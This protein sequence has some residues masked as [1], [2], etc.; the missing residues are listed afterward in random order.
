MKPT[1]STMNKGVFKILFGDYAQFLSEIELKAT[2]KRQELQEKLDVYRKSNME[3]DH[4][5]E[6]IDL[7]INELKEIS[8]KAWE[9]QN[10]LD[11][12]LKGYKEIPDG[13]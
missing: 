7:P 6:A 2:C 13:K 10:R 12:I 1:I 4:G 8:D 9:C 5:Q 3:L 11:E